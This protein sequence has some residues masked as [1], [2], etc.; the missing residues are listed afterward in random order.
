MGCRQGSAQAELVR[1]AVV[2]G[3]IRL[4]PGRRLPG[5][6]AY[7]HA[8]ADCLAAA[9]KRRAL[10]R[11]LRATAEPAPDLADALAAHAKNRDTR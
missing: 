7:L 3:L 10:P 8:D 11:A 9:L 1:L 2:D 6:G 5:R 4:D